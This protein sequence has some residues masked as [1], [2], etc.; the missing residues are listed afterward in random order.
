M[1]D[2]LN[3]NSRSLAQRLVVPESLKRQLSGFRS[4]VWLTKIAE[5]IVLG[6]VGLLLAYLTVYV[7]DRFLDTPREARFG[8][9]VASL[10]LWLVVPWALHRWVWK[11]RRL[12]QLAR[13]LRVREPNVGDQLLSVIELAENETEQARSRTLCAAAISQVA[14]AAKNR[15]FNEA[16]PPTRLRSLSTVLSFSAIA[17]LVLALLFPTAASNAWARFSAPWRN[18]PRYTF[19]ALESIKPNKVVPHG[20]ATPFEFALSADTRWH[21]PTAKLQIENLP[22]VLTNNV[23]D[24]YSYELPP[25]T[26]PVA[27]RLSVGD[28]SQVIRIEPKLR[29][30]LVSATAKV[31]LPAYLERTEPY[32]QDVRSGTLSV[33]EGSQITVQATASRELAHAKINDVA[34]PVNQANFVSSTIAVGAD[35]QTF[36][37]WWQDF[38]GLAGREPFELSLKP[39]IDEFP[40]VVS[41]DL[42]RQA[43]VL[44]SEQLNFLALAADDFGI[45]RIGISWKGVDERLIAKP[46]EGEKVLAAGDSMRTSMQVPATF[47]AAALGITPQPIEVRLWTEDYFPGRERTYTPPHI[48]FVLTAEEHAIWITSQLSKWHRAS[49]DVRDKEMQLHEGNK[50]LREMSAEELADEEMREE[51]RRQ[52]SAESSNAR[53][54]SSLSTTGEDLLRQAARN[55]EIGVGH[56]DRWAEML[57]ILN[58]IGQNRMPSVADLLDKAS[59]QKA[60]ARS[61][62]KPS[63]PQAGKVRSTPA[64][65]AQE[66]PQEDEQKT[67]QNA[68]Q[69]PKITDMESSVQPPEGGEPSEPSKK[70]KNSGSKLSLPQTTLAGPAP[71]SNG[72]QPEEEKEE[73]SEEEPVQMA[74]E[75]QAKLLEEFEKIADE[76]N[77][78]LANLEGSTLVKRLKAAS[79]EQNQVAEK[80]GSRIDAVFGTSTKIADED[81]SMLTELSKVEEK[82]SQNISYIMDDMQAYFERRRMNQ[83]KLVLDDM[84]E[85]K[86]LEA[87]VMLGE[88]IPKEQGMS[89][90][91]AEYWS[92]TLDRWGEDLVDPAC[93]GQCPGSKTSDALPP[94]LILEVLKILESEVNLR[95]ATRVAQ[96][97]RAAVEPSVHNTES[98]RLSETQDGLR[99]RTDDVVS[100]IEELPDGG[101]RFG[102]EVALLSAVSA[103]MTEASDILNSYDTGEP[104]IAAETEAIELLLQCKRI[105]PKGG[106]GGGSSPG[107]GGTGTTQDSALALLGSGLNQNERREARDVAQ[108]TGETGRVLPEEFRAGLDEYFNRLEQNN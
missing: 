56:L 28:Y 78:I 72:E 63:G 76:L 93:S 100:A 38:D 64:G 17:T 99:K 10:A 21:P 104:A 3:S 65:S 62:N 44:D 22:P 71:K 16:A 85:S 1:S 31:S 80:I 15:N 55:P 53:R 36:Q 37:M 73:E 19:T 89:I 105:N 91:Q 12:D 96:Q 49:L 51:L 9:F 83:F 70:K 101:N 35:P 59:T 108:A 47:S 30:E 68:P 46:A 84:K 94:S 66:P 43:V 13:L 2:S 32:D 23:D 77:N 25:Q 20:E 92:D 14:E 74:I 81:R 58:D 39:A 26:N 4:H 107:G 69:M 60:L 50:R 67:A 95:E 87:L 33:V 40:S 61:G 48:L 24:R 86:V 34:A 29:P 57:Q 6:V 88:E 8:I 52:A 54:L 5:A 41:Q 98:K 75:E 27:L 97:A 103:V 45:K 18:T 102:K 90:A 42:P 79:R 82:S 7:C 11:N 106:G